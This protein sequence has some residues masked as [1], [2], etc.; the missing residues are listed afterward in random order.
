M[1]LVVKH[2]M[3]AATATHIVVVIAHIAVAITLHHFDMDLNLVIIDSLLN[4][5][6]VDIVAAGHFVSFTSEHTSI[7]V[8][9]ELIATAL[10]AFTIATSY[11]L[12]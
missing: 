9:I 7:T 8:I 10:I 5:V 4:F 2:T 12:N 1:E 6:T 11:F 3:V